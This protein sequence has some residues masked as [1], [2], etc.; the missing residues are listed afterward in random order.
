MSSEGFGFESED[1]NRR[2]RRLRLIEAR[3]K[4]SHTK[5]QWERL[6]A[7]FDYRCVRCGDGDMLVEKDHIVPIYQ[8]GSDGIDNL[9]PL[10]AY[11]NGSKG[12]ET[13]NWAEYRRLNG[14]ENG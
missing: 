12:P 1:A 13:E 8:G 14:W 3:K 4:G 9:Q 7:E 5:E 10:C 11:C 6:K 2:L